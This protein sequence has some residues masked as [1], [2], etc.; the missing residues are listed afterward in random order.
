LVIRIIASNV[1]T[2]RFRETIILLLC[3]INSIDLDH[4]LHILH[5]HI[6]QIAAHIFVTRGYIR[7]CKAQLVV[8]SPVV[9][10]GGST[11]AEPPLLKCCPPCSRLFSCFFE[12]EKN[13]GPPLQISCPPHL[14]T[15]RGWPT[16]LNDPTGLELVWPDTSLETKYWKQLLKF[17]ICLQLER[18]HTKSIPYLHFLSHDG[19]IV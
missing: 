18:R 14:M 2:E 11:G 8:C 17:T 6:L 3:Q 4:I 19:D 12:F 9:S 16:P 7:S 10:G 15:L 1:P 13:M 5:I